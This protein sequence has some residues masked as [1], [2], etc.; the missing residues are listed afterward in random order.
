MHALTGST[1][2]FS[3]NKPKPKSAQWW[4]EAASIVSSIRVKREVNLLMHRHVVSPGLWLFPSTNVQH[5][6]RQWPVGL[7]LVTWWCSPPHLEVPVLWDW[8]SML[9]PQVCSLCSLYVWKATSL[10]F[11]LDLLLHY[12]TPTITEFLPDGQHLGWAQTSGKPIKLFSPTFLS[13]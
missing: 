11:L 5:S 3:E 1:S 12:T 13:F 9:L 8:A 2:G 10:P 6:R 7:T 4:S